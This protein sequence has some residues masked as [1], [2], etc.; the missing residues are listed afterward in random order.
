M[1]E[2]QAAAQE[3]ASQATVCDTANL[4]QGHLV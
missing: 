1:A 2:E 3:Q 4:H